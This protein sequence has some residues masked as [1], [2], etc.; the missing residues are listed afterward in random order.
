MWVE[1][2]GKVVI[3]ELL[4]SFEK[5]YSIEDVGIESGDQIMAPHRTGLNFGL[6]LSIINVVT[7]VVLLYLRLRYRW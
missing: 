3:D 5:G 7:S 1:R 4:N 2:G 6:I